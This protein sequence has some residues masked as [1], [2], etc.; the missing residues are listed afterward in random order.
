MNPLF[1]LGTGPAETMDKPFCTPYSQ[2]LAEQAN[3]RF[4]S[5]VAQYLRWWAEQH[6]PTTT[7]RSQETD[8]NEFIQKGALLAFFQHHDDA[9]ERLLRQDNIAR[10]LLR[11]ATEVF[12][13]TDAYEP[14]LARFESRIYNL[15]NQR[16][17][18]AVSFRY[19]PRSR[20]D[21]WG[22]S[23]R[24]A[25]MT[26]DRAKEDIGVH[27]GT[28]RSDATALTILAR[29][30]RREALFSPQ[31]PLHVITEGSMTDSLRVARTI[32]QQLHDE[33]QESLCCFIVQCRH[34]AD[35]LHL[36]AALLL[37]DTRQPSLPRRVMFCDT[38]K[39]HALPPWWQKFKRYV[40]TVFP[41]PE[42]QSPASERLED[43]SLNLQRL[44]DGVPVRHQDIDCA[45]YSASIARALIQIA[46]NAPEQIIGGDTSDLVG[47][48]T[49]RMPAYFER[50][51]VA[52]ASKIIREVNVIC[53]WQ[54]GREALTDLWER[55]SNVVA[56][57]TVAT[58]PDSLHWE[59]GSN[60]GL[61]TELSVAA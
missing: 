8:S 59:S 58:E 9:L 40:D 53:R 23:I 52:R 24:L 20:Q 26:A 32:T 35:D 37:M 12:F 60:A 51:N 47:H 57:G 15:S 7:D 39:P 55:C 48:M 13:E 36:G 16:N 1:P 21:A 19:S 2:Q 45:F 33:G 28:R 31:L 43:G 42:A 56:I 50:A 14:L 27:F 4:D 46:R 61:T 10:H 29:Q 34:A 3:L 49:E 25:D 6:P 54:T 41:Q 22:N 44:H 30:L 18:L 5:A 17:Q 38:L 11:P